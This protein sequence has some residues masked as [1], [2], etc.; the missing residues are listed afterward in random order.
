M[1]RNAARAQARSG[2]GG[3]WVWFIPDSVGRGL[4]PLVWPEPSQIDAPSH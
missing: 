4:R 1:R 3:C 2:A